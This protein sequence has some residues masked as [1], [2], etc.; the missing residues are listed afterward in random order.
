M[1]LPHHN[2]HSHS[3][4]SST[5]DSKS[6]STSWNQPPSIPQSSSSRFWTDVLGNSPSPSQHLSSR[7]NASTRITPTESSMPSLPSSLSV[8]QSNQNHA[9]A[10]PNPHSHRRFGC[11]ICGNRFERRGHLESHIEAV[12]EGRRSHR[13]PRGCGK[14]FAHRSSLHRHIKSHHDTHIRES[15]RDGRMNIHLSN[16]SSSTFLQ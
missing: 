12:H 11:H 3:K 15:P 9:T 1:S 5:K 8:T 16:S 6:S 7:A 14:T 13:C 2:D 4:S 10:N